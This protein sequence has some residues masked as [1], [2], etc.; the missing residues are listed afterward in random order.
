ML[1]K[2]AEITVPNTRKRV[3]GAFVKPD[4]SIV[5]A[6]SVLQL[7][8]HCPKSV[9]MVPNNK[10]ERQLFPRTSKSEVGNERAALATPTSTADEFLPSSSLVHSTGL[11]LECSK[12][13][14]T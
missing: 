7:L 5:E 1:A 12:G 2:N 3:T 14:N 6:C 8:S 9:Q 11:L 10:E 13:L 4:D